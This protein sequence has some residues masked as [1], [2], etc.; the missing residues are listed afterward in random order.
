MTFFEY[1][2]NLG[3]DRGKCGIALE[4]N[5]GEN[6]SPYMQQ[7]DL[8]YYDLAMLLV[9]EYMFMPTLPVIR[10]R[11]WITIM[12]IMANRVCI[13]LEAN[14]VKFKQ[15]DRQ[16]SPMGTNTQC[17]MNLSIQTAFI[18]YKLANAVQGLIITA[19]I[20]EVVL[21]MCTQYAFVKDFLNG[22]IICEISATV[23]YDSI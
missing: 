13:S 17:Y 10:S 9:C 7:C 8:I 14:Q 3:T 1:I 23:L 4:D 11:V 5:S 21:I 19:Q 22:R 2:N 12:T 15:S 18:I 16:C 6:I 20:I